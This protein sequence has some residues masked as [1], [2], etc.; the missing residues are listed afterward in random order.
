VELVLGGEP[1]GRR[2]G[3]RPGTSRARQG[4]PDGV[5]VRAQL[6]TCWRAAFGAGV[7]PPAAGHWPGL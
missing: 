3:N 1:T 7:G 2:T 4:R 6:E 5:E